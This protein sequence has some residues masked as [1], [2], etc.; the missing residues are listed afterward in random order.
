MIEWHKIKLK[1]LCLL[2]TDGK[3]GDC[4][5]Q[6]NSG[7]YFLSSKDL[8]DGKLVYNN[9]R[10]ITKKD[11]EETHRRTQ[12]EPNC[13]LLA[14]VGA[15]IGRVGISYD[16]R[17]TKKTTFQKSISVLK[18]N[19]DLIEPRFLYYSMVFNKKLLILLGEGTAQPNLL[20][21]DIRNLKIKLPPLP[22]QK[23]I[24]TILSTY[25]NLIEN[26]QKRIAILEKMTQNLYKEW[27]VRFRFP[28][29][30][31][32]EF[33]DGFPKGWEK[34]KLSSLSTLIKRGITPIY[35]ENG[36][37][38]VINQRCIKNNRLTI[39]VARRQ[40]K[41]IPEEKLVQFGDV[42]VN[43]TGKG[44]LGRVAQVIKNIREKCTV[45]SHVT[46]VRA[47]EKVN[48]DYWG[49]MLMSK[50]LFFENLAIGSTNQTELPRDDIGLIKVLLP[51]IEI[52]NH[53]SRIVQPLRKHIAVLETKN[54][55]LKKTKN[56]LLPRLLSGK[57]KV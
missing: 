44:T 57:L 22:T 47:S 26:N 51:P 37:S 48:I 40:A 5:N 46:I 42:L 6:S 1:E 12:L 17:E 31:E 35:K 3:H 43:S 7:Y 19:K 41:R 55:N 50:K 18:P 45:D 56:H 13:T 38:L 2:I 30:E 9:S 14:N 33:M 36:D 23:K 4:Q 16:K 39:K 10:E 11:F 29:W 8:R 25:D 49:F 28:G 20:L 15:S 24:A 53:F 27:F 52:Q 21:R 32:V 54:Q 34:K